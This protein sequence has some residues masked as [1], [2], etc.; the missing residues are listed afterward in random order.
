MVNGVKAR[1]QEQSTI[2]IGKNAHRATALEPNA[3][4]V[5]FGVEERDGFLS[6]D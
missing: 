5:A 1:I 4:Q 2:L 3:T 6:E